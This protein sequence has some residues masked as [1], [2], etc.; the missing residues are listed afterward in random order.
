MPPGGGGQLVRGDVGD[1]PGGLR[2]AHV[3]AIAKHRE[4]VPEQRIGQFRVRAGGRGEPVVPVQPVRSAGQDAQQGP[5]GHPLAQRGLQRHGHLGG[6]RR[7]VFLQAG[8]TVVVDDQIGV[9][10][11]AGI[12]L[13]ALASQLVLQS[14]AELPCRGGQANLGAEARQQL[15]TAGR[16]DQLGGPVGIRVGP[17]HGDIP[18]AQLFG[19]IGEHAG[20]QVP[21]HEHARMLAVPD[22]GVPLSRGE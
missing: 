9:V 15:G 4:H 19:Q 5:F 16:A 22:R 20:L 6:T 17:V 7:P 18:G 21:A 10:G 2:G 8:P 11:V 14:L 12:G 1:V 13:S 3:G